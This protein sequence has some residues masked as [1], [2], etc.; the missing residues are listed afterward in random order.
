MIREQMGAILRYK[1]FGR[2]RL[3][4]LLHSWKPP[5]QESTSDHFINSHLPDSD[6]LYQGAV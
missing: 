6:R 1:I 5:A 3:T 2:R 4:R